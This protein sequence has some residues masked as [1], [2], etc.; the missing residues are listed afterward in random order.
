MVWLPPPAIFQIKICVYESDYPNIIHRLLGVHAKPEPACSDKHLCAEGTDGISL[1]LPVVLNNKAQIS[2]Y[3]Y[4]DSPPRHAWLELK[5]HRSCV[6]EVVREVCK[7]TRAAHLSLTSRRLHLGKILLGSGLRE[8]FLL[9]IFFCLCETHSDAVV[10]PSLSE[11]LQLDRR[12][13]P[14]AR[15][16]Y[17]VS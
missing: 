3:I 6:L 11:P 17:L 12:L 1:S 14:F 5:L 16:L 7:C 9:L 10:C 4:K 2:T 15:Q 8:I 13:P